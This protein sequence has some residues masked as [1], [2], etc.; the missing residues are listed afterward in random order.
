[1]SNASSAMQSA[2]IQLSIALVTCNRPDSLERALASLRTQSVQP[3]E[4]I[5]SDDSQMEHA[6]ATRTVAAKYGCIYSSGPHRGLYANRNFAAEQCRGTHIRTMDDDHTLPPNHLSQCLEAVGKDSDAIWTT[7]EIG[8]LN[9]EAAGIAETANQ[10]GPAG[11][12]EQIANPDDNW[13]IADGSTVYPREVF[14]RG[15]RMVEGFGFGSSY[16]EFGA[17]L[18]AN[19]W[20][21]RCVRGAK[22]EHHS[23][24]W[25]TPDPLSILFASL[26]FNVH[27]RPNFLRLSRYLLPHWR[28]LHFLP[29]LLQQARRR[30]Q[31]ISSGGL[32]AETSTPNP[33]KLSRS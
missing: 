32:L 33:P 5:V 23:S 16:L 21:C 30:W 18:Y 1:M 17:Y 29:N 28:R 20:K 31:D 6:E 12:G 15:F 22:I 10:L 3:F 27:F 26:C 8:Y 25:S 13:G 4:I 24:M 11:V 9:G 19:G 14:D 7:G 2:D